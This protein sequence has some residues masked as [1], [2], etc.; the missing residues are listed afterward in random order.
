[1]EKSPKDS[2]ET[3]R[4]SLRRVQER[5]RA[6]LV[7]LEQDPEV[8]R[9]LN[10]GRPTPAEGG[11]ADFLMPRGS[12]PDV[13]VAFEKP[14]GGFVGWFILHLTEPGVGELGYRLRREVRGRG[15]ATEGAAGLI[16]KGFVEMGIERITASAMA[17]NEGSRR[18][19]EK[20]GMRHVRTVF[21]E[22]PNP[23][24][25]SEKGEVEYQIRREEWWTVTDDDIWAVEPDVQQLRKAQTLLDTDPKSAIE[26]FHQLAAKGSI[27]S[28]VSLGTIYRR[29]TDIQRDLVEAE[30]W[31]EK[32]AARGHIPG[33]YG[34]ALTHLKAGYY[35]KAVI[36]FEIGANANFIPS[37][38]ML[39]EM[40][41]RAQGVSRNVAK[42]R[43]LWEQ[44]NARGYLPAKAAL[45]RL[46][47][48]GHF[49]VMPGFRGIWL[50][51]E[52]VVLRAHF[53]R[54]NR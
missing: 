44:V 24:P 46:L 45:G 30:R 49:G 21:P 48:E 19:M 15:I 34:L 23:L 31:Y 54:K 4:L 5:D 16:A 39:G 33:S 9:F 8:M 22:W 11:P 42:A 6:D 36:Q 7:A 1:M 52:A 50:R 43:Q 28:M 26:I 25:G 14:A 20:I 3:R 12:E 13:W 2:F 29:G 27:R 53:K 17:V 35:R 37:I 38:Y 32:A 40:L 51:L 10:G 47:M 18:V 41:Y